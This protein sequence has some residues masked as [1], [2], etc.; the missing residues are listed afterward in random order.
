MKASALRKLYDETYAL[1]EFLGELTVILGDRTA[2]TGP[3][4]LKAGETVQFNSRG[5]VL[6]GQVGQ[7]SEDG[8]KLFIYVPNADGFGATG[9]K[10]PRA[11]VV[12]PE[13]ES[14]LTEADVV[15]LGKLLKV[16]RGA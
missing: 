4:G 10:V 14:G 11:S 1:C 7:I 16:K 6:E 15:F 5:R 12:E 2:R 8:E 13:V 9:H 3:P